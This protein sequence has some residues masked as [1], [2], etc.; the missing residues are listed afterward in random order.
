MRKYLPHV[1]YKVS[2][3]GKVI[4]CKCAYCGKDGKFKKDTTYTT[5]KQISLINKSVAEKLLAQ[6]ILESSCKP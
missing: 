4:I 5:R 1:F 2:T 3:K 6:P